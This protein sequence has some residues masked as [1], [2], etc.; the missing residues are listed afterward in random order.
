MKMIDMRRALQNGDPTSNQGILIGSSDSTNHGKRLAV[1]GDFATCPV[2]KDGGPVFND[3]DTHTSLMGK[4][5][6]VEGARVYCK[7]PTKPFVIA[8]QNTMTV[9][10]NRGM[11]APAAGISPAVTPMRAE[12]PEAVNKLASEPSKGDY[13]ESQTLI[14]PNMTN[15][16]FA[17]LAMKLCADLAIR[18]GIRLTQLRRWNA[19]DQRNVVTWFGV[20]DEDTRKTLTNG[21]GRMK[22]VFEA[23]TPS[24][25]VR[26]S[27]TALEYVGC[28]PKP[29]AEH[30]QLLAAVCKPDVKTRTIAIALKFCQIDDDNDRQDSK[31]LTIAH[32]VSHF[33][34]TMDTHDDHYF[35][36]NAIALARKKSPLCI[37]NADNV[38]GYIVV[39]GKIPDNFGTF[40]RG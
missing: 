18:T 15:E 35:L 12:I 9:Q 38:A 27:A 5:L 26:Y 23:L 10:V 36:W 39:H 20:A 25:F 37:R 1:E 21:L 29:G 33:S 17:S 2:C 14:C 32:E 11:G 28:I 6:L 40:I 22:A 4:P 3:C 16:A 24:N 7:C 8:T 19:E 31:L 30:R 34:D 13:A